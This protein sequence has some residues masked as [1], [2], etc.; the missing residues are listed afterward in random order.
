MCNIVDNIVYK[1]V[2]KFYFGVINVYYYY[3][4][5]KENSNKYYKSTS[6]YGCCSGDIKKFRRKYIKPW[7]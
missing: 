1:E 6:Y 7:L 3:R 4:G 2:L 5:E